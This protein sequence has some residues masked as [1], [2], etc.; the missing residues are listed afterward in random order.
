[1]QLLLDHC[2]FLKGRSLGANKY[3]DGIIKYDLL[4][5]HLAHVMLIIF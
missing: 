3:Y 4:S 5:R 1:M 2:N